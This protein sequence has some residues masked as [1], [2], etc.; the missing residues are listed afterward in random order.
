MYFLCF[1]CFPP[2]WVL[3]FSCT[4]QN[5][6]NILFPV[7]RFPQPFPPMDPNI[8]DHTHRHDWASDRS[9]SNL[10]PLIS[11]SLAG[12]GYP[13][14][15]GLA[16]PPLA[17]WS[18]RAGPIQNPADWIHLEACKSHASE[19]VGI[20]KSGFIVTAVILARLGQMSDR[21]KIK[22]VPD[23]QT[24][25]CPKIT[26]VPIKPILLYKKKR[27]TTSTNTRTMYER[28]YGNQN[29]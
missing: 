26:S 17:H 18:D 4:L 20:Y 6:C 29:Q 13:Q 27:T 5:A 22:S 2:F 3:L 12:C 1:L 14:P 10:L 21:P 11:K 19:F 25:C 23:M 16:F 9:P 7:L 8:L 24:E 15:A 28:T